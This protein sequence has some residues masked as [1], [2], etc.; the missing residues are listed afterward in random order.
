MFTRLLLCFGKVALASVSLSLWLSA[1]MPYN[2]SIVFMQKDGTNTVLRDIN[3]VA[4]LKLDGKTL[5]IMGGIQGD[6]PGG[7]NAASIFAAHYKLDDDALVIPASNR[8]SMLLNHRGIYGD[9]NRKFAKLSKNDKEYALVQELKALITNNNIYAIFHLHDGSGFYRAKYISKNLNPDRWGN[10]SIIDQEDIKVGE[11]VVSLKK[12]SSKIVDNV[13]AN[14]VDKSHAYHTRNTKTATSDKEMAKALTFYAINNEKIALAN[15]ASKSLNLYKRVYYHLLALEGFLK[16]M[17]VKYTRDFDLTPSGIY[18]VINDKSMTLTIE[19]ASKLPALT[20]KRELT[21]FPL[22]KEPI[23]NIYID[24]K[25]SYIFG[26]VYRNS[27]IQLKYGNR[28]LTRLRPFYIRYDDSLLGKN[29]D[30]EVDSIA[31]KVPLPAI[32]QV[33]ESFK[34]LPI[35]GYRINIIGYSTRGDEAGHTIYERN[36]LRRYGITRDNKTYRVEIYKLHSPMD[37]DDGSTS[38]KRG[39]RFAGMLLIHFD[40]IRDVAGPT[41]KVA[42]QTAVRKAP[43]VAPAK[44]ASAP[45]KQ[46]P[47]KSV[48]A[49]AKPAPAPTKPAPVKPAPAPTKPVPTKADAASKQAGYELIKTIKPRGDEKR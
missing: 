11:E 30:I 12:M 37:G 46:A 49:P 17:G 32:V 45:V 42:R 9:L 14:L 18:K 7:F 36:M 35:E 16:V 47:V 6:E 13:N 48:V 43:V 10:S 21:Y 44:Q 34:I 26:L 20:L 39:E 3:D 23:K 8:Y 5:L 25:D 27:A 41:H 28:V 15:E 22:P 19:G 31:K 4:K 24:S 29:I 38:N 1:A 2:F 33:K 40:N